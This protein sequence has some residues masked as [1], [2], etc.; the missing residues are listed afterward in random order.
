MFSETGMSKMKRRLLS[1]LVSVFLWTVLLALFV[2]HGAAFAES[3]DTL[4]TKSEDALEA[5]SENALEAASEN[6]LEAA[7]EDALEAA[8]EETLETKSEDT[9][10]TE[11][12]AETIPSD[13]TVTASEDDSNIDFV[14]VLDNS[15]TM[16]RSDPGGLTVDAA[17]MFIDMLPMKNARVAVVE[18]GSNY[19]ENAFSPEKYT[20]YVSVPFPLSDISSIEQKEACK[21]VIGETRQDGDYTP[22]GYAFLAACDVLKQSGAQPGDAGIL[23]ISDFRV[24]GQKREDFLEDGYNYQSLADA[25]RICA[26]NEWP[27]YTLEMNFDG[28]ND[29]PSDYTE[30]I[31]SRIR[32]RIPEESGSGEYVP[33]RK[34]SD[35]QSKFAGIFRMYFDPG[36]QEEAEV[37]TQVTDSNGDA[38]FP[39]SV[40]EMVA[41][42][43]ITLTSADC[44]KIKSVEIGQGDNMVT[45]DMTGYAA[46]LQG[47]DQ[48]ITKEK[49]YITIKLMIPPPGDDWK[50]VVHGEENTELGMYAL[51]IHDMDFRLLAWTVTTY[52]GSPVHF[53]ALYIYDGKRY[54][55]PRVYTVYPAVLQILETGEEIPMKSGD[56]EYFA[57]VPFE[58]EGT[59]TVKA[60]ASGDTFRTGS[61]ET[62]ECRVTVLAPETELETETE[63]ETEAETGTETEAETETGVETETEAE[64]ETESE[65]EKAT[66]PQT[67]KPAR[68][69]TPFVPTPPPPKETSKGID[70]FTIALIGAA[71]LIVLLLILV[72]RRRNR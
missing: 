53:S 65:T 72:I 32:S 24:T 61:I 19:G 55:S 21:Q 41:E 16:A 34:A 56:N 51:S 40:G 28:Q 9:L 42:L 17:K 50:V 43:N 71:V 13:E 47:Q 63:T 39:F 44:S 1:V 2:F 35:A 20:K 46:P 66:E 70:V 58:N 68:V 38:T 3:K 8:S 7:S 18:F 14:L 33:L 36:S 57:D 25:E 48:I 26:E 11:T 22:V 62:G 37:Q 23:L 30:R 5:A 29:H 67:S 31:A 54:H 27:V 6:A 64:T 60:V 49:R 69:R 4:K 12:E 52:A 15:G 10:E 45:Y 59:Y